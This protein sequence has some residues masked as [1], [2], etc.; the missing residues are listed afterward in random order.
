MLGVPTIAR[1]QTPADGLQQEIVQLRKD[2]NALKQDYEARVTALEAKL[3]AAQSATAATPPTQNAVTTAEGTGLPVYSGASSGSK[4]FNP[5]IAVIGN[6]LGTAGHN[7]VAPS[8]ALA[9]PESEVS[10]QAIVDPYARAD[11]FL[12]FGETG[13]DLE[14]GYATF[15]SLPGGLLTRVGKMRSA[16][17]KVNMFHTHVS[18]WA[19]RPLVTVNLLGGEEGLSDA[20]VSVARLIPNPWLFLEVT[21]QVFRGDSEDVFHSSQPGDLSY[22]AHLRGYQDLSESTNIDLGV[23]YSRGHNAAGIVDGT[24]V[25]RFT[26]ELYGV[27]G[28]VRWRPLRRSIYHSFIGRTELVWSRREQFD[29]RQNAMGYFVSAD[30]QLARRWF[31]GI[32]YDRSDRADDASVF[33]RGGSVVLSFWPSEFSQVRGQYRRIRYAS[34]STANELLF[35]LLFSIGAHGAHPF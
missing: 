30:Y 19:D 35:Q 1:A 12:S 32:R 3:T 8:P 2:L 9:I 6:F 20:G 34:D 29:G 4:V 11:F 5:D 28:T 26:T 31:T 16:F 7:E 14:E 22:V 17:G 24:D 18:P 25:G 15:T 27:D 10:F 21:G 23:S 33:D 13:V